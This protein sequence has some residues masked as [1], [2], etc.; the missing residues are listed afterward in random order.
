MTKYLLFFFTFFFFFHFSSLEVNAKEKVNFKTLQSI[1]KFVLASKT[2]LKKQKNFKNSLQSFLNFRKKINSAGL[3]DVSKKT[4]KKV[5]MMQGIYEKMDKKFFVN[6]RSVCLKK[7][8]EEKKRLTTGMKS[9][10]KDK[11]ID[12]AISVAK[13]ICEKAKK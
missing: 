2:N 10:Y 12:T 5:L 8:D 11:D 4:F 7:I 6:S 9:T 1:K 13:V 3:R